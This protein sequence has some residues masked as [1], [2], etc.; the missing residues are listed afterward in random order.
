MEFANCNAS[1]SIK[2]D[3][4]FTKGPHHELRGAL[5][6]ETSTKRRIRNVPMRPD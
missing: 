6:A 3:P 5:D 2:I 1:L 4:Q